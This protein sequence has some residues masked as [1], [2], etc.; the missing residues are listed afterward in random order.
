MNRRLSVLTGALALALT[1]PQAATSM[2]SATGGRTAA[3][4]QPGVSAER[5]PDVET[6]LGRLRADA[7]GSLRVHRA[8]DGVV[9]FVSSTDGES[10]VEARGTTVPSRT[11]V[12]Q[13][14]RYGEA[15]G[16]DGD[17]SRAVV[18]DTLD[19]A[20]GGSVVRAEQVVDGVPVFGGQVVM[21]LDENLGVVSVDAATT[22]A[23]EVPA[24]AVSEARARKSALAA[25]AKTHRVSRAELTASDRGRRLYDPALL[26]TSD[27]LG[28]R[29]VWEF[30]VGNGSEIRETVLV[31]T[32]RGEVALH[33]NDAPALSRVVCDNSSAR[34]VTSDEAVPP[35]TA[36]ARSEGGGTS[37]VAD[38]NA[39]Y[40]H[41]GATSDAYDQL[42][43]ID[44]TALIGVGS[45]KRLMS[46]VRWCFADDPEPDPDDDGCPYL[47]AFWDGTQMVIGAGW[48]AADDVVAHELTHGY[49]QRTS[50]LFPYQQSG[51]LDESLADVIGEVVDHRYNPSGPENNTAWDLGEALPVGRVRSLKDP[52]LLNQPDKM[53]SSKFVNADFFNDTGAIHANNGVGNKTAYLISQGGTFNGRTVTGIDGSDAGLAKTG[54]LY[55]EVIPRLTSGAE[56]ADLGRVLGTVCD[57]LEAGDVAGFTTDDCASVRTAAAA[58]ELAL[59]PANAAAAA[60]EAPLT[61]AAGT[62]MVTLRRD[63]D[64]TNTFGFA[65]QGA[66]WQRTPANETPSYARSGTSSWFGLSP[67][68]SFDGISSSALTTASFGVPASQSTYLHFNHAYLFEWYDADTSFP[69]F[70]PDGGQVLVQTLS[71][72]TWTSRTVPWINA[73]NRSWGST[74]AKVFGGDS[75]GYGSSRVDLSSLA[76]QTVRIVFKVLGDQDIYLLG[77]WLDDL[78][79]YTC[80][81]SVASVPRTTAVTG[82]ST[83]K[84]SW[85]APAYVG[86]SPIASYRITRSDGRIT[87]VAATARTATL[88]GLN[89]NAALTV[90]VA[91]VN[92]LGQVGAAGS[93]RIDPTATAVGAPVKVRKNRAFTVTGRVVKRGTTSVIAGAP[94]IL[95]RRLAT[96]SV[97]SNV[98]TGTTNSLGVKAWAVRQQKGTYYRVLSR[99]VRTFFASTSGARLV[100]KG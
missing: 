15:F 92:G 19:S 8:A 35:C 13:L 75:H 14:A 86:T 47:N 39:A 16:I 4:Q 11:A 55:L 77:W 90:K 18:S 67:D 17:T 48:A 84:V 45:P 24:P 25:T 37:G 82:P 49:V 5:D 85:T 12:D 60:A 96:S 44:L 76:G 68:P 34:T 9:D 69:A 81:N 43:D 38:V 42:A 26:H 23:T 79:L 66:L 93:V 94:V 10:M 62:R 28:V 52:L 53:T 91:A 80:P 3:T 33:F 89:L 1:A 88:A 64:G 61:C 31:G 71:G 29:P 87:N 97:W 63:D 41:L 27:H 74:T 50:G 20:T 22:S 46:T 58:T 21:S 95:Q 83:V 99:G 51:A 7:N 36:P 100:K 6:A 54:L 73:P 72:S 30:E 70:Y 78:R 65:A 40:N 59:P 98:A 32:T 2:A 57:E 56:Y